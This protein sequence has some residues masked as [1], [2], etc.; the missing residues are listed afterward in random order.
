VQWRTVSGRRRTTAGPK[1]G[2]RAFTDRSPSSP[3]ISS[4]IKNGE[5][6]TDNPICKRN[7]L[8]QVPRILWI[9]AAFWAIRTVLR[10]ARSAGA[11]MNLFEKRRSHRHANTVAALVY[12]KR[13][14]LLA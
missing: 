13:E 2:I 7:L 12:R 9:T 4:A 11:A 10:K 6:V 14:K 8:Q 3:E 1:E 5:A